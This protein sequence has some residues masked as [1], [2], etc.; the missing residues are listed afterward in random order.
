MQLWI[1]L[2]FTSA[3]FN[4]LGSVVAKKY[5]TT[6]D[7]YALIWG[8]YLFSIPLLVLALASVGIPKADYVFW[9]MIAILMPLEIMLAL[10]FMKSYKITPISKVAPFSSFTPLFISLTALPLLGERLS[11][12]H[13]VALGLLS[14]GAYIMS[15]ENRNS[16]LAPLNYIR[17]EKG[18]LYTLFGC[19]LIGFTVPLGKIAIIHSSTEFFSAIYFVVFV[20]AFFPI[21]A[22]KSQAGIAKIRKNIWPMIVIGFSSSMF[23]L[24]GWS[25][26][27]YGQVALVN[28]LGSTG[29][30]FTVI[31]AG[32]YL[33]ENGITRRLVASL[34]MFSGAFLIIMFK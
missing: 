33:K 30:L 8:K 31:L 27:K 15:L 7:E 11:M 16:I 19:L 1:I 17:N 22:H 21:F 32:A 18:I 23:F 12:I 9:S 26:A 5:I 28:A 2:A 13:V 10:A 34:V 4:A 6:L 24:C 29:S 3:I 20:I 14:L 25:A